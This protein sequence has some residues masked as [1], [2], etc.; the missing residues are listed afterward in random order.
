MVGTDISI[1]D[2]V[3]TDARGV[4]Q[5][6]FL[7]DTEL[8]V[9]PRSALVIRDY[10]LRE[11]KSEGRMVLDALAGTFRF[12]TGIG[13]KD[14]YQI[15]TPTATLGVRGT[16]FDFH[17]EPLLTTA[18]AYEGVVI[19]CDEDGEGCAQLSA[20]CEIGQTDKKNAK[21]LGIGRGAEG[22]DSRFFRTAFRFAVSQ[23]GLLPDFRI[24]NARRCSR[25]VPVV[26]SFRASSA[27]NAPGVE[28]PPGEEPPVEEPPVEPPSSGNCAGQS[29]PNP[30]NSQN[31]T[32][33]K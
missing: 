3:M 15:N 13:R 2:T 14:Q 32:G 29:R 6:R 20:T 12:V 17:V 7:D 11:D 28:E 10:L 30:G 33:K 16:A 19:M 26:A 4:V 5:I 27:G 22:I 8:V 31:C 23:S 21:V 25:S 24:A 1:G 18:M 9:G